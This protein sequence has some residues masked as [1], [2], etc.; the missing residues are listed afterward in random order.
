MKGRAL[1]DL[2]AHKLACGEYGEISDD[3][4]APLVADGAFDPKAAA[5]GEPEAPAEAPKPARR[6][7]E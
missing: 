4:A 3:I 6:R 5:Q 2:P 7:K 1:I